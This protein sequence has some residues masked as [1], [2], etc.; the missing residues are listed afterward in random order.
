[1]PTNRPHLWAWLS[2]FAEQEGVQFALE[3]YTGWR[4]TV[5]ELLAAGITPHLAE[6]AET[7]AMRGKKLHAKTDKIGALIRPRV[8]RRSPANPCARGTRT[9]SASSRA[10]CC[11][12]SFSR[13]TGPLGREAPG[14][15]M[16]PGPVPPPHRPRRDPQVVCDLVNRVAAGEPPSGLHPQPLRPLLLGGRVPAPLRIPHVP[17]IRQRPPGVTTASQQALRVQPGCLVGVIE[18]GV[19]DSANVA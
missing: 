16:L 5:E 3:S 17:V 10:H 12:L 13:D 2:R 19:V 11:G 1:M 6:S 9:I 4:H 15:A 7:V 14:S 18:P 8:H